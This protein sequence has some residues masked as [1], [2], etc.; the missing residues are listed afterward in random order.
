VPPPIFSSRNAVNRCYDNPFKSTRRENDKNLT[1]L[2]K[3]KLLT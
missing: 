3:L 2:G 1:K